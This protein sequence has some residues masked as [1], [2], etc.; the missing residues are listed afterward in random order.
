[1]SNPRQTSFPLSNRRLLRQSQQARLFSKPRARNCAA[2]VALLTSTS[3]FALAQAQAPLTSVGQD[4]TAGWNELGT[5]DL[6]DN[7][8]ARWTYHNEN[9]PFFGVNDPL[10]SKQAPDQF[11]TEALSGSGLS[12]SGLSGSSGLTAFAWGQDSPNADWFGHGTAAL[13]DAGLPTTSNPT[14]ALYAGQKDKR[15][16]LY[17]GAHTGTLGFGLHAGLFANAQASFRLSGDFLHVGLGLAGEDTD[18]LSSSGG[19]TTGYTYNA[20]AVVENISVAMSGNY[21]PSNGGFF[22]GGGAQLG[23]PHLTLK[24]SGK[25]YEGANSVPYALNAKVEP[26]WPVGPYASLGYSAQL[27]ASTGISFFGELGASYFGPVA[28][29]QTTTLDCSSFATAEAQADCQ[30]VKDDFTNAVDNFK[31]QYFYPVIRLGFSYRF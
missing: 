28:T 20:S 1:M 11:L 9:L 19:S 17:M 18:A 4:W 23:A 15:P 5:N 13:G 3:T 31:A 8:P 21:H 29:S 27:Q 25:I 12:G 7:S 14:D 26:S 16:K 2:A 30:T 6:A 22:V 10:T 24:S